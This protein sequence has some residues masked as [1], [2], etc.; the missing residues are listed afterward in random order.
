MPSHLP[1]AIAGA[2]DDP[3]RARPAQAP[4][5]SLL[6]L[7]G[8]VLRHRWLIAA[9]TVVA[10]LIAA[11][12]TLARPR[13]YSSSVIF[14]PQAR[15]VPAGMAGIAAQFG[16][17]LS[18]AD[19]GQSPQFYVDLLVS[20]DALE[21]MVDKR[22]AAGQG[23]ARRAGTLVELFEA[24][25][26]TPPLRRER[27]ITLL[28]DVLEVASSPKTNVVTFTVRT[29][30]ATLS[31]AVAEEGIAY[32]NRFNVQ[33]RQSQARAER[34]FSERRRDEA[35]SKL[36]DAENRLRDFQLRNRV[37][38]EAPALLLERQRLQR[39]V[40]AQQRMYA[41]FVDAYERARLDEIRDTPVITVVSAPKVAVRP[42]G[43]GLISRTALGLVG[44][45]VLGLLVAVGRETWRA[46][47]PDANAARGPAGAPPLPPSAP[48]ATELLGAPGPA[49]EPRRTTA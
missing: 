48:V 46:R 17:D 13:T 44:G 15:R 22:Y 5:V 35:A 4:D 27:A 20:R 40:D 49:F 32:V 25:G 38:D 28:R 39:E 45:A 31:Q 18:S 10:A 19:G 16:V 41:A 7:A 29:D 34:E 9:C 30:D 12:V 23:G 42:D 37:F 33:T 43:R 47:V 14:L 6:A 36:R 2:A 1:S 11:G 26:P 24:D 21:A 8:T 3:L